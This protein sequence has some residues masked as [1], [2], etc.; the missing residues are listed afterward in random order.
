M[1]A[2]SLVLGLGMMFVYYYEVVIFAK[3]IL[4]KTSEKKWVCALIA[5]LN[6][7]AYYILYSIGIPFVWTLL[8]T[9]ALLLLEFKIIS[10]SHIRQ[11]TFGA[12]VFM[13]N[14]TA[15]NTLIL[16]IFSHTTAT[17][18]LMV[19]QNQV[20][21]FV[22]IFISYF[23]LFVLLKLLGKI[24]PMEKFKGMSSTKM[25]SEVVSIT[26]TL[27]TL[28]LWISIWVSLTNELYIL[29]LFSTITSVTTM[30][31]AFYCLFFFNV[32]LITLHS[33]K[34]K[35]DRAEMMHK[36]NIEKQ[37]L[38]EKKLYTDELT[39]VYNKRFIDNKME[40]FCE[41][42]QFD[43]AVVYGDLAALKHVNDN[44]GHGFGDKYI[45]SVARALTKSVRNDDFVARIGGDEFLVL[46]YMITKHD[47]ELVIKRMRENLKSEDE[48]TDFNIHVNLGYVFIGS[49]HTERD[50]LQIREKADKLMQA[51]KRAYYAKG[52]GTQ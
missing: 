24:V 48:K 42:T 12:S 11:L 33:F 13:F 5:I 22:N 15:I 10:K 23:I 25:Y 19:F 43:F 17:P 51:D 37:T 28:Y 4:T 1:K 20:L 7:A 29:Y 3:N 2:M 6:T 46:L 40:R 49:D 52:G 39:G 14:I 36:I 44:F 26:A 34:R 45:T 38:A 16:I 27:M 35:S 47:L 32:K 9:G 18:A 31:I 50:M 30:C 21:F 8:C 41:Q